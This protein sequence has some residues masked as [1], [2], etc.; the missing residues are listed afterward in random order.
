MTNHH[1]PK[2][3]RLQFIALARLLDKLAKAG[4]K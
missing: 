2:Q 1:T 3:Q 4:V